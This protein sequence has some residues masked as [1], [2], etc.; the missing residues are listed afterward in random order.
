MIIRQDYRRLRLSQGSSARWYQNIRS[1][2]CIHLYNY[3]H[4]RMAINRNPTNLFNEVSE[5]S[6]QENDDIIRHMTLFGHYRNN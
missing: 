6:H 5:L 4:W 2:Y 3:V 1:Y